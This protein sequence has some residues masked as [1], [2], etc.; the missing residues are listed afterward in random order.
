MDGNLDYVR[1]DW[2]R[3]LRRHEIGRKEA[4][5]VLSAMK[6]RLEFLQNLHLRIAD[7][8]EVAKGEKDVEQ[9]IKQQAEEI[10][11]VEMYLNQTSD[12][13]ERR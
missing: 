3:R 6:V 1:V 5:D 12:A 13:N 10:R 11:V 8:P 4:Q 2:L 9:E 7:D